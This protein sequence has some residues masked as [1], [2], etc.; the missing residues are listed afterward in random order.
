MSSIEAFT[1]ESNNITDS[2]VLGPLQT[3]MALVY[4]FIPKRSGLLIISM[5]MIT[6]F[7]R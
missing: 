4:T 6:L 1:G 3:E 2:I 7:V 5:I